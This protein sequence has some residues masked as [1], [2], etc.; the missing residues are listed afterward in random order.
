MLQGTGRWPKPFP[1]TGDPLKPLYMASIQPAS[2]SPGVQGRVLQ[3][4]LKCP[5]KG[6]PRDV[7]QALGPV[8]LTA[9]SGHEQQ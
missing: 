9:L 2:R 8:G 7:H 4:R 3:E 6:D 5:S 1:P